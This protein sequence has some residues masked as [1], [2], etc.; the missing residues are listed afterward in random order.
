MLPKLDLFRALACLTVIALAPAASAY[1]DSGSTG[2]YDSK[3]S[4]NC[5]HGD[6][7]CAANY[8]TTE[9]TKN[10]PTAASPY[11]PNANPNCSPGQLGCSANYPTS[12]QSKVNPSQPGK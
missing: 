6:R 3:A 4:P 9:L 12:D 7:D 11:D 1:A 10:N 8:P 5:S 2:P